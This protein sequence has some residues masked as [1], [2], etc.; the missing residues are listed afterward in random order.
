MQWPIYIIHSMDK[1]KL[2]GITHLWK[3]ESVVK[4]Y[5]DDAYKCKLMF[6]TRRQ[7]PAS[8]LLLPPQF[9][10]LKNAAGTFTNYFTS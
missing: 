5:G 8:A 3:R 2:F 7:Q 9:P 4:I 10:Y 6:L 1:T